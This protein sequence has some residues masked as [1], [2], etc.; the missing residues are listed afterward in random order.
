MK[1]LLRIL[2][3]VSAAGTRW[4]RGCL[5][6]L[7][8]LV[9]SSS[10]SAQTFTSTLIP[11]SVFARMKG[12]TYKQNCTV[13]RSELRY[14]RLSFWD[15]EGKSQVGE[16]VC[17]KAIAQDLVEIFRELYEAHYRIE[18]MQLMDDYDADD[19]RAMEAN[20]TMCFNFRYVSGTRTVSKHG[21]GMA[22]DVNTLYNP[23][24]YARAGKQHVEPASAAKWATNRDR[25][26]DIPY[27]IDHEDLCYKLFRKHGFR[28]GGDW[29]RSKDYQHFEK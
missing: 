9:L 27:K 2:S 21:R 18:R 8:G 23:Y 13:P 1:H 14:L 10:V 7:T 20:N 12:K 11:D 5:V 15:G 6:L 25:R 24:I 26:T 3:P 17:N 22:V 29:L 4:K 19:Q 28:W 16:M